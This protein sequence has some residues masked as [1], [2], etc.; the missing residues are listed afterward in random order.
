MSLSSLLPHALETLK[1]H[2]SKVCWTEPLLAAGFT[3]PLCGRFDPT[4][5]T[6]AQEI[7]QL[8]AGNFTTTRLLTQHGSSFTGTFMNHTDVS[9]KLTSL[10]HVL[11]VCML[12]VVCCAAVLLCCCLRRGGCHQRNCD[13]VDTTPLARVSTTGNTWINS[14]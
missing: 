9:F 2:K 4:M 1:T 14:I 5:A 11:C 12:Y 13:N 3:Q 8:G 6:R 7:K 10:M